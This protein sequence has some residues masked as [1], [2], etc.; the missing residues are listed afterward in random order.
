[1]QLPR[2][3]VFAFLDELSGRDTVE[4][5]RTVEGLGYGV[6]WI[7]EALGRDAYA[8]AGHLLAATDRLVVG[9][10][11]ASIWTR[12]PQQAIAAAR[13]HA[14]ASGGRFVLG[15]GVNN[16]ASAT[17]RGFIYEKP[18]TAMRR[19]LEA[20]RTTP[21]TA[22][23]PPAEPPVVLA[24]LQPRMQALAATD[25]GGVLTYFATPGHTR[26]TRTALGDRLVC[27]EQ[28]VLLESDAARARTAARAYMRFYVEG[29]PVYRTHLASLGFDEA[30]FAG[31]LSDRLVDAI[32]AWGGPE[33]I[34]ERLAAHV[35][36]GADHVCLLPLPVGGGHAPDRGALEAL[37]PR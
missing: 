26:R 33:R 18:V 4:L 27:V 3:G 9:S 22:P 12:T 6:L 17:M 29:L 16:P 8:H 23:A 5:A 7:V 24:A 28:A 35:E 30:D 31:D 15:L 19:Y 21:W 36:A 37:A 1:M 25:A 34:R 32:V 11:V 14:E 20:M 13:T 2:F 10:G